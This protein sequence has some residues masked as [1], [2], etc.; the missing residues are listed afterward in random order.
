M[1][2]VPSVQVAWDQ[3]TPFGPDG[4]LEKRRPISFTLLNVRTQ[5]LVVQCLKH[6]T[7]TSSLVVSIQRKHI[8]ER[9]V[10]EGRDPCLFCSLTYIKH[11]QQHLGYF[12]CLI[13]LCSLMD[14]HFRIFPETGRTCL[15]F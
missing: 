9:M 15:D 1:H 2:M 11:Q 12:L 13:N 5:S 7:F 4:R 6:I 8:L 3:Q 10:P 14:I